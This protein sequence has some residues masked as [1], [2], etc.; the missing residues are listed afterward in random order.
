MLVALLPSVVRGS[1]SAAL[2]L[3]V[4]GMEGSAKIKLLMQINFSDN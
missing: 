1:S 2:R 3:A 4:R